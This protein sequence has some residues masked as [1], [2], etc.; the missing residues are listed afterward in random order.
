MTVAVAGALMKG[1]QRNDFI[2]A[3]KKYGRLY[4]GAGYGGRFRAWLFSD[5]REPYCSWDNGSAMRTA[6]VGWYFGSLEATRRAAAL[7]AGMTHDH[8]E[9]IKGAESTA[10]SIFLA[11]TGHT[12]N[13][14]WAYVEREFDYDLSRSLVEI[15]PGYRFHVSC[16]ETVPQAITAFLESADFE[17]AI[18]TPSPWAG[19]ATRW[20]QSPARSRGRPTAFRSG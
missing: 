3:M 12:K 5:S 20:P 7:A 17:D 11:R 8:P 10:S 16:Q 14:I 4:P 1:A 19:T 6:A 15:R 13:E 18:R 9:G 2:D